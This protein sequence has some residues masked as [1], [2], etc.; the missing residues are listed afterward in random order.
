[1][2]QGREVLR[3]LIIALA[4]CLSRSANANPY[5]DCILQY[6]AG[7]QN[8][9]AAYAIERACISKTTVAVPV[10]ILPAWNESQVSSTAGDFNVGAG[11]LER[12]IVI[13]ITNPIPFDLT[14]V[15]VNIMNKTTKVAKNYDVTSSEIQS[16]VRDS[17]RARQIRLSTC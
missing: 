1:M 16:M 7:A 6:M 9:T 15:Q 10:D 2:E 5:D 17:T 11:H 4:V 8:Q 14:E 3:L 12:G 13:W